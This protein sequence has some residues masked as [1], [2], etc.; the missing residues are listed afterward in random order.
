MPKRW[1]EYVH[2]DLDAGAALVTLESRE[3]G[4]SGICRAD[5]QLRIGLI[6]ELLGGELPNDRLMFEAP[7]TTLQS[8]FVERGRLRRQPRQRVPERGHRAR[9]PAARPPGGHARGASRSRSVEGA[10]ATPSTS[11]SR[12]S[13]WPRPSTST[14]T[15]SA[16]SWP[17]RTRDRITVDFFGD[18]LVC[19]LSEPDER[20][21]T[22]AT[23]TVRCR[24][25]RGT[26]A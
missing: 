18:Q 5:G 4:H 10:R 2:D 14:S 26:S 8:Y 6:E 17:G 21:R 15:S 13:T 19:H 7:T 24:C 22:S 9:D 3:S 1:I 16:A 12:S 11:P 25:T 23:A 20:G